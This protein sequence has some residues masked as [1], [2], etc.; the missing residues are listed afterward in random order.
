MSTV[1][2]ENVPQ[3]GDADVAMTFTHGMGLIWLVDR[4]AHCSELAEL[5]GFPI[6]DDAVAAAAGASHSFSD[7]CATPVVNRSHH[8]QSGQIGNSMVPGMLG[9]FELLL[10]CL[11]PAGTSALANEFTLSFLI[12]S[13]SY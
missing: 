9:M 4:F 13:R 2:L 11:I 12:Y 6:R 7:C 10:L 3:Y 5:M 1:T 8:S